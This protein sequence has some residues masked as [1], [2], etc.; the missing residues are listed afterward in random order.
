MADKRL[1]TK[2]K[3]I[4]AVKSMCIEAN[5]IVPDD[6]LNAFKDALRRRNPR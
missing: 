4:E 5:C 2:D 6:M 3:I 1:V